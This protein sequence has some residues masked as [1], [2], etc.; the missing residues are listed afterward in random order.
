MSAPPLKPATTALLLVDYQVGLC[1]ADDRCVAPPLAAQV[2]ARAT[3]TVAAGVLAAARQA[4]L[5]I[6]H[7]RLGFDRAYALR[8][9]RT[10]RF[11]RYPGERLLLEDGPTAE[12]V[13]ELEPVDEAIVTKGC[14]DPFIGTPL[15]PALVANRIDTLIIGGV[16]TNLAV[17]SAARHAADCGLQPIVVED[18]CASFSPEIHELAVQQTIPLFAHV[19]TSAD[20]R[21]ALA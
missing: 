17:E 16:A 21:M 9:N 13:P 12:I 18:M 1:R 7:A 3:L 11:D 10:P 14:I 20:I 5:L 19:A 8:T 6:V 2:E 4:H 15:L